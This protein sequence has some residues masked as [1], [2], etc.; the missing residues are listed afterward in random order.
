MNIQVFHCLLRFHFLLVFAQSILLN[1]GEKAN[2]E[3]LQ[4][5]RADQSLLPSIHLHTFSV[6]NLAHISENCVNKT[7]QIRIITLTN[8]NQRPRA[9]VAAEYRKI[10][11]TMKRNRGKQLA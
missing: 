4:L 11:I 5:R 7:R 2:N 8:H 1:T 9:H 10:T 3:R 6:L